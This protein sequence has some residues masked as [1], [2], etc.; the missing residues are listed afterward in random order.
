MRVMYITMAIT[1]NKPH[2]CG[3]WYDDDDI[4]ILIMLYL[5]IF[6]EGQ[7]FP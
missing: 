3:A 2:K 7:S 5:F 4:I 6:Y 1:N